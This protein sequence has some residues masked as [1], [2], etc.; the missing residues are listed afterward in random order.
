MRCVSS[1]FCYCYCFCFFC[2]TQSLILWPSAFRPAECCWMS[3]PG[4]VFRYC[5]DNPSP[6]QSQKRSARKLQGTT[7]FCRHEDNDTKTSYSYTQSEYKDDRDAYKP[8]RIELNED[9][10]ICCIRIILS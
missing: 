5:E 9:D 6:M 7:C 4:E 3:N 10:A 8:P 2:V 1:L